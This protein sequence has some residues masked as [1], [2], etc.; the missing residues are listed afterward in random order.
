MTLFARYTTS[1]LVSLLD[2][3]YRSD[4]FTLSSIHSSN[5]RIIPVSENIS[6][7]QVELAG[8]SKEEIEIYTEKDNLYVKANKS[9]DNLASKYYRSWPIAENERIGSIKYANGL[10]TIEILK[11][12]PE[13]QMRKNL[14]IE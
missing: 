9:E 3:I 5:S 1:N 10:L 13:Q 11:V 7:L 14:Q 8:F 12:I 2:E 6:K 4:K